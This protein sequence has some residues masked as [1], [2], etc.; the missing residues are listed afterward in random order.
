MC[1]VVF[2]DMRADSQT[3]RQTD[4][5]FAILRIPN[6]GEVNTLVGCRYYGRRHPPTA[7]YRPAAMR[8]ADGY[9][10]RAPPAT[11]IRATS[12][13][14]YGG[15]YKRADDG[16]G[17]RGRR[18][19]AT[20]RDS[21]SLFYGDGEVD[22]DGYTHIWELP[23]PGAPPTGRQCHVTTAAM[24]LPVGGSVLSS[25]NGS[26]PASLAHK[27]RGA[28][29]QGPP[30]PPPPPAPLPPLNISSQSLCQDAAVSSSGE[31]PNY[32]QLDAKDGDKSP[33]E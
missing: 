2:W 19:S 13:S 21:C 7:S 16:D 30:P 32:Y 8:G 33:L 28:A 15:K 18:Q 3:D 25:D 31:L 27:C 4:R 10:L 22:R 11:D 12:A 5:L 20:S 26:C 23:L 17:Y 24:L 9:Q 1:R 6:G 29:V 14:V